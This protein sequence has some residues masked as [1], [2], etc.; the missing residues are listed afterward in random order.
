MNRRTLLIP[1]AL[2]ACSCVT[3]ELASEG[4]PCG[5]GQACGPGTSCDPVSKTC[6][7][8]PPA[9]AAAADAPHRDGK[10]RP[11]AGARDG[12]RRDKVPLLDQRPADQ[13]PDDAGCP[14]GQTRCAGKCVDTSRNKSH[15][16]G[17]NKKCDSNTSNR[18][19]KGKCACGK[20]AGSAAPAC[21]NGLNCVAGACKCIKGGLCKGCCKANACFI[22][23]TSTCGNGGV[24]CVDCDDKNTCTTDACNSG[25]SCANTPQVNKTCDDKNL[26]TKND[27]CSAAGKCQGT[28][29]KC[30]DG[31][32]CTADTC[33]GSGGCSYKINSGSC[34]ISAAGAAKQ[35]Y[36]TGASKQGDGCQVCDSAKSQTGWTQPAACYGY[37]NVASVVPY[38]SMS[39]PRDV[40]VTSN[41]EILVADTAAN[42]I[43]KISSTGVS[44]LA[45]STSS[46]GFKDGTGSAARFH[47]PHAIAQDPNGN[48]IVADRLNHAIRKVTSGG[49]VTTIA[50]GGPGAKGSTD[51]AGNIARFNYPS[52]VVV[53]PS[54]II[55]VSDTYNHTIRRIVGTTVS[56]VAGTAG[57]S[58]STNAYGAAARFYYP[59][60]I[61]Y[62]NTYLF[63]ADTNNNKIRVVFPGTNFYVG[64]TAGTGVKSSVDGSTSTATFNHPVDVFAI[65]SQSMYVVEY[66]GHRLRHIKGSLVSTLAGGPT[67]GYQDGP[68]S[69]ARFRYPFGVYVANVSYKG[70]V[71][72]ADHGNKTIRLVK[73][74]AAP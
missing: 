31:L 4:R 69:A 13:R 7:A 73:L 65:S 46:W 52:G 64:T 42:V 24:P 48:I 51:G 10:G 55:Y 44:V 41:G 14:T 54:G 53:D 16:G 72:V 37:N 9:D 57:Q 58:G 8:G 2:L 30:S 59:Q 60:G 22:S 38:G 27:K 23:V 28:S 12:A 43:R 21:S 18:C 34:A 29:Y 39:G 45:G 20:T 33:N 5:P 26:C 71:Y 61:T 70:W 49:V 67:Y 17:C 62:A 1:L 25:G 19:V 40:W 68:A 56:T 35:C 66:Y 3:G 47:T 63:V 36:I 15:C 11:E 50:G 32:P 6:K 74:T